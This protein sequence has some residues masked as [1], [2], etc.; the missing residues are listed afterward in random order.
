ML[1]HLTIPLLRGGILGLAP[2]NPAVRGEIKLDSTSG[3]SRAYLD[4]LAQRQSSFLVNTQLTLGRPV[5]VL[6]NYR[7][8]F[9]GVALAMTAAEAAKVSRMSGV[10]QVQAEKIYHLNF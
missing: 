3:P 10:K 9:N 2:T 7:Y 6:A 1:R 5:T 8:A 4:Y